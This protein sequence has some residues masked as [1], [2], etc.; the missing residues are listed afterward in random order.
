MVFYGGVK[1]LQIPRIPKKAQRALLL[2]SAML[3]YNVG[4]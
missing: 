3:Q 2:R 1:V 4:E